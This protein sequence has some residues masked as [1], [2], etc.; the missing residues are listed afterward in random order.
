MTFW[1]NLSASV[2]CFMAFPLW[3]SHPF[4]SWLK[5]IR[6]GPLARAGGGMLL[7][8]DRSATFLGGIPCI[9]RPHAMGRPSLFVAHDVLHMMIPGFPCQV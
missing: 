9:P 7:M 5:E 2:H 4:C 3:L 6:H 8:L 1:L